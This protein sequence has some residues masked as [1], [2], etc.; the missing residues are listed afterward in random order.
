[1]G[2]PG[3]VDTTGHVGS[4]VILPGWAGLHAA[5]ELS[6][7][8]G[9]TV[10]VDNDANLGA[11]GEVAFGAGR[12]A[13]DVIYVKASSGVGAGIVLGGRLHRGA[14]GIA[15]EIGHI[16]VDR[17]ERVCRCG[18]RGCLETV[19]AMPALLE[20]LRPV[21]GDGLTPARLVE[22][23]RDGDL[24]TVRQLTDAGRAVGQ[25]LA[26]LCNA[27]NPELI[28]VG[29]DLA[30]TGD[31]LLGGIR[32]SVSRFALPG[33]ADA[34]RVTA[35]VLGDRA[36]VLGS[37]ALVIG[38]AEGVVPGSPKAPAPI[39]TAGTAGPTTITIR[40][41]PAIARGGGGFS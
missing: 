24:A 7:R 23:A 4:T 9:L 18:N 2:L 3:P 20:L 19:A 17:S 28:I 35:G 37:L 12:G 27:L 39:S 31:A 26:G 13:G 25:T 10:E 8:I 6:D 38:N 30:A 33:A 41:D 21:H 11:L 29:G 40:N 16:Q 1:M 14:T 34:V 36:E 5:R 22:M 15:G 32:E